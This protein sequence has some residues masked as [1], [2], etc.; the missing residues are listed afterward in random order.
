MQMP[1]LHP[2]LAVAFLGMVSLPVPTAV[3]AQDATFFDHIEVRRISIPARVLDGRGKALPGL[4]ADD[5]V[6]IVDGKPITPEAA[7]WIEAGAESPAVLEPVP[8]V[9]E[10]S[11]PARGRLIVLFFQLDFDRSRLPGLVRMA[12]RAGDL[13]E[14][15]SPEDRVAVVTFDHHLELRLDFTA[16]HDL[17]YEAVLPTSLF[18]KPG[19]PR[20]PD[21]PSL[22]PHSDA[23]A[24]RTAY[25]PDNGL[26]VLAE[27]LEHLPG[28]KTV[29]FFGWGIGRFSRTGVRMNRDYGQARRA[30][31]RAAA[32]VFTLDVTNADYH[33]LEFGLRK[34][35]GDTGGF[36]ARTHEFPMGVMDRLVETLSGHY[37][38]VFASPTEERG[39]HSLEIRLKGRRGDVLARSFFVD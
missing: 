9:G 3:Q 25:Y 10:R 29:V 31:A 1:R 33:S 19:D 2:L 30:L 28:T 15:L 22:L 26:L 16:D 11:E 5:F 21:N 39:H 27:A 35:S 32:S 23:E 6:V 38:I 24:A 14:V 20:T 7:D 36:Y 17:L 8:L 12:H 13:I 34:V 37:M 18:H 4:T